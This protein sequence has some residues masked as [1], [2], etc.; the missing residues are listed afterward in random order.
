MDLRLSYTLSHLDE[1]ME[2]KV[3]PCARE[4]G[5]GRREDMFNGDETEKKRDPS[6]PKAR[7]L[8]RRC[9]S[10]DTE[11]ERERSEFGS[12]ALDRLG[13]RRQFPLP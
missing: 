10:F 2:T 1:G 6:P 12:V 5:K 8:R 7:T 9:Q 11:G 3:T 4:R 13:R